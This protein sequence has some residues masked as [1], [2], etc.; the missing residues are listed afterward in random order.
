M[1]SGYHITLLTDTLTVNHRTSQYAIDMQGKD[2]ILVYNGTNQYRALSGFVRDTFSFDGFRYKVEDLVSK[3]PDGTNVTDTGTYTTTISGTARVIQESNGEDVTAEFAI[4]PTPGKLRITPKN[5]TITAK[6]VEHEYDGLP[7]GYQDNA[8]PY[9]KDGLIGS[10]NIVKYKMTGERTIVG[11]ETIHVIADSVVIENSSHT[12]VTSNYH[13]TVVDS[14]V[15]ITPRTTLYTI[16]LVSKGSEITYDS[17]DHLLTGF[18]DT[19]FTKIVG[20]MSTP[21]QYHVEG[22]SATTGTQNSVG[23][24]A[25]VISGTPVVKDAENNIVTDQFE[26]T[27]TVDTLVINKLAITITADDSVKLYDGTALTDQGYRDNPPVLAANDY[28]ASVT[29]VGSQTEVGHSDNVPSAAVIKRTSTDADVTDN[30][31]ITYA[32]GTLTVNANPKT[33]EIASLSDTVIYDA[34][35]HK[36]EVYTV[37]YGDETVTSDASGKVFTLSTGDKLTIT[38]AFDGIT[39]VADNAENNNRFTYTLENNSYY[40]GTRDTTFGTVVINQREIT[41]SVPNAPDVLYTGLEQASAETYTF[42]NVVD[43]E[44]A[45]IA[46]V[47]AKGTN[48]GTYTG[49]YPDV[50]TVMHGEND[51]TTDYTLTTK[52]PG[53]L[54][55]N[56]ASVTVKA[57]DKTKIYGDADPELTWTATGM[58]NSED[59][60][61]LLTVTTTREAGETVGTYTITPSGEAVQGNYNVVYETG[62]LTIVKDTVTVT[63]N[64]QTK[65]YGDADETLTATLTGLNTGDS[66]SLIAY[67][68]NRAAAP[69]LRNRA[70]TM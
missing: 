20:S 24:Y 25:N 61:S 63:A 3:F 35:V 4:T 57:D 58:Q 7:H 2:T 32:N 21:V 46:Y 68:L 53:T 36:K 50:F 56:R 59:A 13:I 64:A 8:T 37:K 45:T 43:G 15:R 22:M 62:T 14:A 54:T 67:T 9:E 5:M 44:T 30:Y 38:P 70:T 34:E 39:H 16:E 47:A 69:V 42:S 65:V 51:V 23:K 26:V 41:V 33:L 27:Q 10:D 1:T 28:V 48:V 66:Q 19:V 55:I 12:N 40:T 60:H 6:G 17:E 11:R 31:A 29:V 52:T 18:V 49:S